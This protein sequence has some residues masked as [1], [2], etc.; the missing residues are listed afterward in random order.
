MSSTETLIFD[1]GPLSHFARESWLGVL[2]AVVGDRRAMVP[3]TVV[4]ELQIGARRDSRIQ[5]AL[6][7]GWIERRVL[8]APIEMT[9][10]AKYSKDW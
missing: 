9:A 4:S 1:T 10:F 6:D 2:K 8:A 3:D 5:A 7:A